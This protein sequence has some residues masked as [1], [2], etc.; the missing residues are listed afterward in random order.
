MRLGSCMILLRTRTKALWVRKN[1]KV[2]LQDSTH[3]SQ[4]YIRS[5][6]PEF[7]QEVLLLSS[8]MIQ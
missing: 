4:R 3:E 8:C 6:V 1:F 2:L 5:M 7:D